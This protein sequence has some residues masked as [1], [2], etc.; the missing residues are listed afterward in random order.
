MKE[1]F[2]KISGD[3]LP[4]KDG[5]YICRDIDTQSDVSEIQLYNFKNGSFDNGIDTV[6]PVWWLKPIDEPTINWD[7]LEKEL[8]K[9]YEKDESKSDFGSDFNS[10]LDVAFDWLKSKLEGKSLGDGYSSTF[11]KY[12][13]G[14]RK[15]FENSIKEDWVNKFSVNERVKMENLLIAYD[16]MVLKL[17][18]PKQ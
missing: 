18:P 2:E 9:I 6:F 14:E 11:L 10:G 3:E 1:Y 8:E 7:E 5:E 15:A 12:I 16:Q 13:N 4:D 17:T